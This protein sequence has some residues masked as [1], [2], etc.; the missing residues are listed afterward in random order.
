IGVGRLVTADHL[1]PILA[2]VTCN[3]RRQLNYPDDVTIGARVTRIGNT[4]LTMEHAVWSH[5]QQATAADGTS[6]VVIFDY[7]AQQ[8]VRV[9]DD[10]RRR[11]AEIEGREIGS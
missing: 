11:I 8:P 2:R 10:F 5:A 3:Y 4:S 1:G 6:V 9:P 7:L